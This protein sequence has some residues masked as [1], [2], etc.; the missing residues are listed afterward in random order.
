MYLIEEY[1]KLSESTHILRV[2]ERKE[3]AEHFIKRFKHLDNS[4]LT[5]ELQDFYYSYG[6]I[7]LVLIK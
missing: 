4:R 2:C 1:D 5:L 6:I 7:E 3:V